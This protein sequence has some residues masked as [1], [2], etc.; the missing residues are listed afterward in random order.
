M[1]LTNYLLIFTNISIFD[2][3]NKESIF[4]YVNGKRFNEL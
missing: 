4:L 3:I 1:I 2:L